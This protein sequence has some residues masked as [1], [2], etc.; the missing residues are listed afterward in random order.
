[1]QTITVVA[2][3]PSPFTLS[4]METLVGSALVIAVLAWMVFA[5]LRRQR[6]QQ[7]HA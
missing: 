2:S 1:V 4:E 7:P 3:R 6:Q 5:R